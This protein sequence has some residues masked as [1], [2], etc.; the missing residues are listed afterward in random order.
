L[1]EDGLV[2]PVG[3]FECDMIAEAARKNQRK[4]NLEYIYFLEYPNV[5]GGEKYQF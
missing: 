3:I 5:Q 2:K 4:L 1:L